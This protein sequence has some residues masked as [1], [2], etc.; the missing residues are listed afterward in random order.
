MPP[1]DTLQDLR[2]EMVLTMES[3]GIP[4]EAHHHEVATAGQ[5]EIDMRFQEIVRM[6]DQVLMYK[7]VTKNVARKNGMVVTFMPKPLF[8]DNGSGMH[9]HQSLWKGGKPLFAGDRYAGLSQL[10]A[11]LH[12]RRAQA[13]ARDRGLHQ[14]DDELVPAARPGLRGAGEPGALVAQ[15]LGVVPHPDVLE[16]PEG[17]A[18]RGPLPGSDLQPVPR[19]R[20]D[21]D[22]RHRRDREQDRSG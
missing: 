3:L 12:R 13:L 5:C 10:G 17:Q 11:A 20:G 6:A 16:Q 22:G 2:T 19:L 14:P 8:A 18:R 15:P 4:I 7:Y 21:A 9:C 1:T